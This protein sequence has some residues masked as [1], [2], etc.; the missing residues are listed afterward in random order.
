MA[1]RQTALGDSIPLAA[2]VCRECG[3]RGM[4]ELRHDYKGKSRW[5]CHDCLTRYRY[6]YMQKRGEFLPNRVVGDMLRW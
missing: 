1:K 4:S 6:D 5:L 2:R 3:R